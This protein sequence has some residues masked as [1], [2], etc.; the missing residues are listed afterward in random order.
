MYLRMITMGRSSAEPFSSPLM[1]IDSLTP[2]NH[3]QNRYFSL[4]LL[5][6]SLH[7]FYL[8]QCKFLQDSEEGNCDTTNVIEA[9]YT[10]L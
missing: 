10:I 5:D 8:A 4:E 9:K 6:H 3:M 2:M 1:C 7:N